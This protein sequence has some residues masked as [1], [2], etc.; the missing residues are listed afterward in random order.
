MTPYPEDWPRYYNGT[1]STPCDMLEGP[2]ACG[3][4][5][6]LKEWPERMAKSNFEDPRVLD[7]LDDLLK[8]ETRLDG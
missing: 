4:T 2:C 6:D 1:T 8:M 3:A 7:E 5:H